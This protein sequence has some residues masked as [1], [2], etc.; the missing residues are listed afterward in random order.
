MSY[1]DYLKRNVFPGESGGDYDALFGYSNRPGGQFG[2]TRLTDM[3]VSQALAFADPSGP[4]GQW[5]KGQVG[6]VAT[7]MGAYQVVGSTLRAAK[8]GLGLTGNE[9]MTPELQDQIGM[10]IYQNQG[11]GAWEA[12]GK[13]GGGGRLNVSSKGAPMGLLN[14]EE[15]QRPQTFM[16]RLGIQRRDPAAGGQ[17]ALPFYQRDNFSDFMGTLGATL[18]GMDIT[19]RDMAPAAIAGVERRKDKRAQK[20]TLNRT[21]AWLEA[22]G[23]PDLAE[24]VRSGV[25]GGGDAFG[26]MNQKPE[27][28]G[29]IVDAATLRQLF[30]GAQIEE[31]L[32]NLK[33]DGTA[34]KIGGGGTTIN[35]PDQLGTIP[36]GYRVVYDA[37]NRPVSMEPIPGSPAAI[38][39]ATAAEK[40]TSAAE[41]EQQGVDVVLSAIS[42]ARRS[43][44]G[45]GLPATGLGGQILSNVGGTNAR[46]LWSSLQTI[47]GAIAIDRLMAMKA[48]SP[49]GGAL[50]AVSQTEL[51]MLKA[52]IG[53]LEQS[54]DEAQFLANLARV[55][56]QYKRIR[57]KAPSAFGGGGSGGAGVTL[58]PEAQ[59]Y[60]EGN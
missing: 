16:E 1:L 6:R 26:I 40:A 11:P 55:E 31:G 10:W 15:E 5:V 44:T 45:P 7:P 48:A 57:E 46:N 36:P 28:R 23:R 27:E 39:A 13:G 37:N 24:A 8:D 29:Q 14:F 54:Q 34:N 52:S 49:T 20:E 30:P 58:S 22:Q 17:T 56:E 18:M 35:M 47:T 33:A 59:R 50:G 4:Y 51:D 12:W 2:G 9:R 43:V 3:T 53:A 21:A 60:L 32:Y 38:E 42:D 25:I 41:Q 19:T